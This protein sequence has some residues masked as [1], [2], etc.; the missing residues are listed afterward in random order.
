[1]ASC[2]QRQHVRHHHPNRQGYGS[3]QPRW[4]GIRD[5]LTTLYCCVPCHKREPIGSREGGE[6][7]GRPVFGVVKHGLCSRR[8][9]HAIHVA[10]LGST[11]HRRPG[12]QCAGH[13]QRD[14]RCLRYRTLS[15]AAREHAQS[16]WLARPRGRSIV[17]TIYMRTSISHTRSQAT[18]DPGWVW[19]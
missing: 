2:E 6:D 10:A 11:G 5:P 3:A 9:G 15:G 17:S 7:R 12:S 8:P 14:G 13:Y 16:P 1:M 4:V 19:E 18:L